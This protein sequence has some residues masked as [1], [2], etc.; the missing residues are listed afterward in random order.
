MIYSLQHWRQKSKQSLYFIRSKWNIRQVAVSFGED[1][2]VSLWMHC[3]N[4][5]V[6]N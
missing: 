6:I 5:G 3:L 1:N 4:S 2:L